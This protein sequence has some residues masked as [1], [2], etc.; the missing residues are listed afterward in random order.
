MQNIGF[1][2]NQY[3]VP[4]IEKILTIHFGHLQ[5]DFRVLSKQLLLRDSIPA[6]FSF[7]FYSPKLQI[8]GRE[9]V[10]GLPGLS[11]VPRL[12]AMPLGL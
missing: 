4:I 7:H 8:L 5:N 1:V 11:S 6:I 2:G 12:S 10:W 3:S 9:I